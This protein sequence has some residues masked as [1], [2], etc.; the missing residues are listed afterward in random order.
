MRSLWGEIKVIDKVTVSV[1]YRT[2]G[3]VPFPANPSDAWCG[4]QRLLFADETG[5]NLSG[6]LQL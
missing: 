3:G 5:M 6:A 2:L 4:F 1:F